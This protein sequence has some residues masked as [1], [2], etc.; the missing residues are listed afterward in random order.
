M[1]NE[2]KLDYV[3]FLKALN[4][5][6]MTDA[7]IAINILANLQHIPFRHGQCKNMINVLKTKLNFTW[8]YRSGSNPFIS[9]SV[10]ENYHRSV[11]GNPHLTYHKRLSTLCKLINEKICTE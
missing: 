11:N 9:G 7:Y 4:S 2:S 10:M 6:D 5:A 8:R 1:E 3:G